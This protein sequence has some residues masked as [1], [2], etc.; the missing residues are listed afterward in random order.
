VCFKGYAG[1]IS[2]VASN[3]FEI[4]KTAKL[5]LVCHLPIVNAISVEYLLEQGGL[6]CS[7]VGVDLFKY[8]AGTNAQKFRQALAGPDSNGE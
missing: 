8:Y 1:I 7:T 2:K 5:E 4:W 3:D 6:S